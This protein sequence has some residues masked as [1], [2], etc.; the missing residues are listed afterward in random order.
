MLSGTYEPRWRSLRFDAL[1]VERRWPDGAPSPPPLMADSGSESSAEAKARG[2][3][4]PKFD[5]IKWEDA[6]E[7]ECRLQESVPHEG[8]SAHDWRRQA[9][10]I[11]HLNERFNLRTGGPSDS[12]MRARVGKMLLRIKAKLEAAKN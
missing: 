8:H 5:W 2:G 11:N 7:T 1:Q 6:L 9:D 10:A 12:I 4:P 3:R